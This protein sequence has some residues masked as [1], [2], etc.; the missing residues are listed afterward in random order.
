MDR[1]L[2][3]ALFVYRSLP[4]WFSANT[5][6]NWPRV[7]YLT[8]V[9]IKAESLVT[10]NLTDNSTCFVHSAVQR[11][12]ILRIRQN[13]LQWRESWMQDP[14]ILFANLLTTGFVQALPPSINALTRTLSPS[15]SS[16]SRCINYRD[17][18]SE[19]VCVGESHGYSISMQCS[20]TCY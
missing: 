19:V 11:Q 4:K 14:W 17:S 20:N 18:K 3:A 6:A 13:L 8:N 5:Q 12:R 10:F 9:G 15:E 16:R 2:L 7:N 1:L